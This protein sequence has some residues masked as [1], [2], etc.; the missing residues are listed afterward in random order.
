MA[1]V[2]NPAHVLMSDAKTGDVPTGYAEFIIQEMI[3]NSKVMQLANYHEMKGADGNPVMEKDFTFLGD[4]PGAYWVGEGEKINTS[5][6]TWLKAKMVSKKLGVI[7]PVSREYLHY[8]MANFFDEVKPKIAEAFYK[9]FDEAGILNHE[10][11]F[12]QSIEQSVT[13]AD[14][15]KTGAITYEN[16]LDLQDVL[17]ENGVVGNAFISK[18]QNRTALRK[19]RDG[20]NNELYERGTN[21]LDGLPVADL[22]SAEMKKGTIYH[23]DFNHLHYGIPYTLTYSISEEATL[24]TI[25]NEDG[26]DVN[27]FEQELIALR[28]T[29]DVAF[30]ITKDGAFAKLSEA[31][32][33]P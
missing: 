25:K 17:Y 5:K 20:A 26:T 10:N 4:G 18:V 31:P 21:M 9:K 29:M 23:G 13:E 2:F 24:S 28:A 14:T 3:E 32:K 11:P 30:M 8:T 12:A 6:V 7:I 27:L 15:A 16:I 19:A 33:I 22:N 1:K